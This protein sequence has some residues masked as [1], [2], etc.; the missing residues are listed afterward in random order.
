MEGNFIKRT[1]EPQVTERDASCNDEMAEVGMEQEIVLVV[2]GST[3]NTT[4]CSVGN[5]NLLI[6]LVMC[7]L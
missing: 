6:Q 4:Y 1:N 2:D 7:W 3:S 5:N